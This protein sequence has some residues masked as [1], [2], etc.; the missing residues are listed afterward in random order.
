MLSCIDSKGWVV[1]MILHGYSN[2]EDFSLFIQF[3]V[4]IYK[5]EGINIGKEAIIIADNA[6]PHWSI[7][8]KDL[9]NNLKLNWLWGVKYSCEY[10]P[11][12]W[13]FSR[14]KFLIKSSETMIK[15][16]FGFFSGD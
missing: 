5:I 4:L 13:L 9:K 3:L 10:A 15:A 1:S 8:V 2:S 11:I 14:L 12:E 7:I 16:K 6:K